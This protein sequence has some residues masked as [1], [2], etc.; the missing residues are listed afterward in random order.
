MNG[1]LIYR[2]WLLDLYD[3]DL[4]GKDSNY[5]VPIEVVRQNIKDAPT[6]DYTKPAEW[7]DDEE[8]DGYRCSFCRVHQSHK[9]QYCPD[10]GAYMMN[11]R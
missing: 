5:S 6:V 7:V 4:K 1:E 10:C 3:V 2:D 9:S 11:A 8:C